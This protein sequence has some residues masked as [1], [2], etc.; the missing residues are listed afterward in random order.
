LAPASKLEEKRGLSSPS[1]LL[2]PRLLASMLHPLLFSP[3]VGREVDKDIIAQIPLHVPKV[4]QQ[5]NGEECGI[6]VLYFIHLFMRDAPKSECSEGYPV[7]EEVDKF[8]E[9]V[10]LFLAGNKDNVTSEVDLP[11]MKEEEMEEEQMPAKIASSRKRGY[12]TCHH[13]YAMEEGRRICVAWNDIGQPEKLKSLK[14]AQ[15]P[16]DDSTPH[17]VA[18]RND[19]YTKV[20]CPDRPGRVSGV[21]T[22][23]TP[24]SM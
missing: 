7:L 16:S 18:T 24:T 15:P 6:F 17:Q 2:H 20:L 22:G 9:K 13:V 10:R 3:L 23:P 11:N 12:T 4:P 14:S 21:G 8:D 19:T 5:K 1:L